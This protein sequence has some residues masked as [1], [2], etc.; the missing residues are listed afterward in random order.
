[1]AEAR[2][3]RMATVDSKGLPHVIPVVIALSGDTAYWATDEKPKRSRA[4]KRLDNIRSTPTV[5][6]VADHY[7]EDWNAV[8]WVRATGPARILDPGDEWTRALELLAEKYPQ[9]RGEPP[10]GPVVAID[11]DR[12]TAWEASAVSIE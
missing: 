5:Q 9:Y 6:L 1:M 3:A 10:S 8:W 7:E 4:L 12:W 2:V 11:I